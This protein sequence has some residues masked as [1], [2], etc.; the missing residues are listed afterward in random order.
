MG[1]F[2]IE[3]QL[4]KSVQDIANGNFIKS[5]VIE[6]SSVGI[7]GIIT[8]S[9]SC[10]V[11][12][13]Q[14]EK[15]ITVAVF[16]RVDEG[17]TLENNAVVSFERD[18]LFYPYVAYTSSLESVSG[19]SFVDLFGDECGLDLKQIRNAF[20]GLLPYVEL[21]NKVSEKYNSQIIVADDALEFGR[22]YKMLAS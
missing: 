15:A 18:T 11:E 14:V 17:K 20:E 6:K 5:D 19:I 9:F 8:H 3:N 12:L 10:E 2:H 16:F 7:G 21:L 13:P 22:E 1:S 4:S